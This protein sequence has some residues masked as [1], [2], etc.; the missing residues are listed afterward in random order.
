MAFP[1][2]GWLPLEGQD[3]LATQLISNDIR[4]QLVP[5]VAKPV[6]L[7]AGFAGPGALS[8]IPCFYDLAQADNRLMVEW[9]LTCQ[10]KWSTK[11]SLALLEMLGLRKFKLQ[12][13]RYT[14]AEILQSEV[15]RKAYDLVII[16]CPPRLTT[17]AI[18]GGIKKRRSVGNSSPAHRLCIYF[19]YYSFRDATCCLKATRERA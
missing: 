9:L 17:S 18:C 13:V 2:G 4:P 7:E 8:V 3:S 15:V 12:D 6:P 10:P 19:L 1:Q 11:F 14:L 5:S 16:D